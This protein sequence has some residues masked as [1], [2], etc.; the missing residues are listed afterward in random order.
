MSARAYGP[1]FR[2][3]TATQLSKNAQ[4]KKHVIHEKKKKI[5]LSF[6]K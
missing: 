1:T 4:I 5:E 3:L 2:I 6:N